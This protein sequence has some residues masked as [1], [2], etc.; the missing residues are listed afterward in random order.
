M[1]QTPLLGS[2]ETQQPPGLILKIKHF[3]AILRGMFYICS[4]DDERNPGIRF[5]NPGSNPRS[6]RQVRRGATGGAAREGRACGA[7]HQPPRSRR[8]GRRDRRVR[9]AFAQADAQSRSGDPW[10]SACLSP[11]PSSSRFKSAG[12]TKRCSRPTRDALVRGGNELRGGRSGGRDRARAPR[13]VK[14]AS[15]GGLAIHWPGAREVGRVLAKAAKRKGSQV[16]ENKQSRETA[17]RNRS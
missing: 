8:L 10:R 3:L 14:R 1:R 9:G 7:D 13:I 2:I 17:K 5:R 15:K 12:S 4:Y 11:R 16:L 6:P